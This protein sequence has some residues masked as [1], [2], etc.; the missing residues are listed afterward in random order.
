MAI[1]ELPELIIA[2][3]KPTSADTKSATIKTILVHLQDDASLNPRLD[4]A[5]AM[6]RACSAHLTCLHITPIEAYI[7][8]DSFG[9][10]FVMNDIIGAL[11]ESERKLR[12]RIEERLRAEDV[13]WN[14]EQTTGSVE[15]Q[16][17][18]RAALADIVVVGRSPHRSDFAGPAIGFLGD[19]ICKSRTPLFIAPDNGAQCDPNGAALIAWDGSYEAANAVRSAVGLLKLAS[20][21]KVLTIEEKAEMF[22]GTRLLEYLSRHGIHA[23]LSLETAGPDSRDPEFVAAALVEAALVAK[24]YL[25][26]GGYNHSRVR[27]YVFGG[28]TRTMLSGA[29]VPLLIAR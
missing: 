29:P 23:E 12:S 20:S 5:L 27:E 22:P 15:S 26:M 8:F 25:V 10:V 14:Y 18:G 16:I 21:V 11:D 3:Q 2:E 19:L 13:S 4:S 1:H 24:A 6:A 7:A 28:V 17:I 9:G